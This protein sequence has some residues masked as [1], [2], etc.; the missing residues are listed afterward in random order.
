VI[1]HL[2]DTNW[3]TFLVGA[4]SL[5]LVLVLKRWLPLVPG[6]LVAVI[7]GIL[8]VWVFGLDEKGVKIVGHIDSGLPALGLPNGVGWRDYLSLFG[9]RLVCS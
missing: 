2:P 8:A 7:L 5:V 4:F 1:K 9:P 3:L 6:S